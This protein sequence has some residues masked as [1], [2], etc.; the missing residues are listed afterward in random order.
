MCAQ[1]QWQTSQIGRFVDSGQVALLTPRPTE[2]AQP[3]AGD[4]TDRGRAPGHRA[5]QGR[6]E[7]AEGQQHIA[8]IE[9]GNQRGLVV[10]QLGRRHLQMLHFEAGAIHPQQQQMR[11]R[12]LRPLSNGG[13][14]RAEISLCLLA[15]GQPWRQ[16]QPPPGRMVRSRGRA[17]LHHAEAAGTGRAD[18]T[19]QEP[20][21]QLRGAGRA[22]RWLQPGLHLPRDGRFGE[23]NDANGG[24]Q[25]ASP[26]Q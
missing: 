20:F 8:A 4:A 1:S 7:A 6:S 17:Q 13:Q 16:L 18:G 24:V 12:R 3:L 14:A 2:C 26:P 10:G 11:S 15:P 23:D 21:G 5:E 22:Q 9:A 25:G 19:A